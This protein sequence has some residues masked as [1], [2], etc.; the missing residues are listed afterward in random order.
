LLCLGRWLIE[1]KIWVDHLVRGRKQSAPHVSPTETPG[2]I[3][4]AQEQEVKQDNQKRY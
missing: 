4:P 1:L 2:V 3:T